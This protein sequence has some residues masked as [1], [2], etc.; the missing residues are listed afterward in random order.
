MDW[1][2]NNLYWADSAWARIQVMDLNNL[3]YTEIL[4]TG[5][6]TNPSAIA[7]DPIAR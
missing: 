2:T 4:S 5:P 1:I 3:N 7:V 6:N